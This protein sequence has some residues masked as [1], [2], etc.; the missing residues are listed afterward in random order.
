MNVMLPEAKEYWRGSGKTG[1]FNFI[2][3]EPE[4]S[5]MSS[6]EIKEL[7]EMKLWNYPEISIVESGQNNQDC[8][9]LKLKVGLDAFDSENRDLFSKQG[10]FLEVKSDGVELVYEK[11]SGL[12]N[13]LQP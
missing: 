5:G 4:L 13:G 1:Q 9:R 6:D 3:L 2:K 7:L 11:R 8:L 12:V 10:Y